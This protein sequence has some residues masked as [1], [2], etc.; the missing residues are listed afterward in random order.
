LSR[1]LSPL[2]VVFLTVFID[3][4]GFGIVIPLVPLYAE[5]Y[6]PSPF[7][8]GVLMASFSAMQFLF[9]PLLGRLS[10]RIGRRP[11]LL[12]SLLGSFLSYLLF[13]FSSS[14]ALLLASRVL[15][16]IMGAN[17]GTAQAVIADVTPQGDRAR[18]MG[19]IGMAFGLGFV[20]GPAIGGFAVKVHPFL[21]GL[22]AA[23]LSLVAF[24]WAFFGLPETRPAA[25]ALRPAR[26]AFPLRAVIQAVR[27]PVVGPLLVITLINTTAFS[28]FE[29]TF[30]QFARSRFGHDPSTVS[31]LFVLIGVTAAIVQGGLIRRLVPLL[32]EA[33]LIGIGAT[34]LALSFAGLVLVS[35]HGGLIALVV[36]TA[37]GSGLTN[38]ALAGL[39]S[40]S[41]DAAEQ[42]EILGAAQS[43]SSLGRIIGPFWGEHVWF[44]WEAAGPYGTGAL[45]EVVVV[46]IVLVGLR[47][48]ASPAPSP[49]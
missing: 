21:P 20:F 44:R 45:L 47:A 46:L 38:P 29:A 41:T 36:T 39:L 33:R 6:R 9:A 5:A 13:A 28:N 17:I 27:L 26:R 34:L 23:G 49:S 18:G 19:L 43:L 11:V 40:R 8:F 3:L 7:A 16:G 37:A 12:V 24:V 14:F 1:R 4:V 31:W 15:A 30:A 25:A 32:G 22:V 42:G 35:G 48:V 10:D 2:A